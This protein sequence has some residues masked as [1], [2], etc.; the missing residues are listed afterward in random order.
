MHQGINV[1]F[2]LTSQGRV[3]PPPQWLSML[4]LANTEF[5]VE[6]QTEYPS[7]T[8][9]VNFR[10]LRHKRIFEKKKIISANLPL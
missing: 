7:G 4:N 10:E 1:F 5:S 3:Q 8:L 2:E 9:Q 6:I